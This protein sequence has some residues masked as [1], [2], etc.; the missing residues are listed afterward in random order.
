M[1]REDFCQK[2]V[3]TL[4]ARNMP[5]DYD[6]AVCQAINAFNM[7]K[8]DVLKNNAEFTTAGRQALKGGDE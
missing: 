7:I 5:F 2:M 8:R 6:T 1:N 3:I 4:A